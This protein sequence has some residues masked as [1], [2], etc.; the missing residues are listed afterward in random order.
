SNQIPDFLALT[1]DASDNIP[2]V[3]GIGNVTAKKLLREFNSLDDIYANIDKIKGSVKEKL[4]V[5]KEIAY[6]SKS[7]TELKI[8]ENLKLIE[9]KEQREELKKELEALELHT[10]YNRLFKEDLG[11]MSVEKLENAYTVVIYVD[12]KIYKVEKSKVDIVNS[13]NIEACK[14]FYDFK[15]IYKKYRKIVD[16][17]YDLAVISWLNDPDTKGLVKSKD[18]NIDSFISKVIRVFPLEIEDLKKKNLLEIYTTIER[19]VIVILAEM[20]LT[21]I[22]IDREKLN[23]ISLE[24]EKTKN[25]L[26]KRILEYLDCDINLNSPKQ[27]SD[28]LYNRLGI[29]PV[30]KTKTGLSTSEDSLKEIIIKYP[31]YKHLIDDILQYREINKLLTTYT[32]KLVTYID[33]KTGRI[34]TEFRQTGT[35]TGRLSSNN[36]NLQN[37]PQRGELAKS[38]RSA[39]ISEEGCSFVSFDYSQIELRILAHLS[40]DENLVTAFQK[41]Y[42]IHSLTAKMIF[43]LGDLSLVSPDMRRIAKAINFGIIYGLSPYGLS[44]EIGISQ[45]EA[46]EFINRYFTLYPKVKTYINRIVELARKNGYT[47]TIFK[48]RRYIKDISSRNNLIRK[49]AERVAINAPIQGSAADIIKLAMIKTSEFIKERSYD[50]RLLLQ[51]HD[52]LIVEVSDDVVE[53]ATKGIKAIME[54]AANLEVALVVNSG[55]GKN[56]GALKV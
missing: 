39:F 24:I 46:K 42:D 13:F 33:E 23:G 55:V 38:I 22:K 48:R 45:S 9:T 43:N 5:G 16:D 17:Y 27:L 28:V 56:L 44:K 25:K 4:L 6:L 31:N 50:A 20:E 8:I 41:G 32:K 11:N 21:G 53:I 14:Y 49:K 51:I 47:E 7:L 29:K 18:E 26:E 40:K 1:G 37:I 19:K 34:H 3:K 52:E 30:Q 54:S 35:A 10:L 15:N 2:G 12:N 36:P